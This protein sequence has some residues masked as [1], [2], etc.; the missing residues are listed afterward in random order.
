MKRPAAIA[1][2]T[3]CCIMATARPVLAVAS[4]G[5][6]KKTSRDI[7]LLDIFFVILQKISTK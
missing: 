5:R 3:A 2:I 6:A 1:T 7:T 4:G